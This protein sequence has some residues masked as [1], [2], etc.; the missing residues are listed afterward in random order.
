VSSDQYTFEDPPKKYADIAL[1][2][3]QDGSGLDAKLKDT[4][5]LGVHS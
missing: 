5:D 4:A 3:Y 2:R 1:A